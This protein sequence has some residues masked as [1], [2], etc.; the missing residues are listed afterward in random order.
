VSAARTGARGGPSS[1][2]P[3]GGI[4]AEVGLARVAAVAALIIV[5]LA[6]QS[7]V[8]ARLTILGVIPQV[9]LVVVISLAYTDGERVGVVTGFAAG[10]LQDLLLPPQSIMGLTAL[11]Y[12]FVG[13]SAGKLSQFAPRDAV[14]TPV[15]TVAVASALSELGYALLSILMGRAWV[16]LVYTAKVAGLV[17]LYNTLLTPFVYPLVRRFADRFRPERI[18]RWE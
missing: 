16:G 10:L 11:V 17:V 9:V 15:A 18:Y 3:A 13:Y 8:L 4:L 1:D 6:L 5:A 2:A 14:W 12:T 7:T